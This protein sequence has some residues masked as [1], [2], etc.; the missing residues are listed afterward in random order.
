[1]HAT[2]MAQARRKRGQT[3]RDGAVWV[4][5]IEALRQVGAATVGT[6]QRARLWLQVACDDTQQRRLSRT[7]GARQRDAFGSADIQVNTVVSEEL[8][9]PAT[10]LQALAP[11]NGPPRGDGRVGQ[12]QHDR[13]VV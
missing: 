4:E 2:G 5:Q 9:T 10:D 13:V 1:M 7:V 12:F 3:L 11:K 6:D 8:S